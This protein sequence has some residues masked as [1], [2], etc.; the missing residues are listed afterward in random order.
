MIFKKAISLF[1]A[2]LV[3]FS[4]GAN[5][6]L[7]I[8]GGDY[9][10]VGIYIKSLDDNKVLV[11]ENATTA[12][13]PASVTKAVTSATALQ[14]LGSDFCFTTP[15]ELNGGRSAANR[16]TWEGTIVINASGDPTI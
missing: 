14:L 16:A 7:D 2:T 4:V 9:T 6:I 12:L 15:V 5:N 8:E 3:I 13:T 10:S 11:N 1:A